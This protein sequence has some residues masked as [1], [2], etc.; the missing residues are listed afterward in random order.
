MLLEHRQNSTWRRQPRSSINREAT[1]IVSEFDQ[2]RDQ[3]F[4]AQRSAGDFVFDDSVAS[5]FDDMISR[6][7]PGYRTIIS[8]IGVMANRH[9]QE[10][11]AIY[12]LGCSL[13]AA[14]F[15]MAE[16]VS[17]KDYRIHAIDNSP[18]M[19]SRLQDRLRSSGTPQIVAQCADIAEVEIINASVVVLN[20]TLQF[21]AKASRD[22]L[23]KKVYEGLRPGGVLIISEKIEFPDPNL[24]DLFTELYYNFKE[25]MGYSKM[26]IAQKRTALENVLVP[27]TLDGHRQRLSAAGFSALDV[28]F[29]C[30][31]FASL[32]A[33]K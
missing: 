30:F 23:I 10:R 11:S 2:S 25:Q 33:V 27:E 15:A 22:A 8:M 16:Q 31:N 5:V 1:K 21:V 19:I 7:I 24:N 12:D 3:L 32:V 6:S 28:W 4:T 9:C 17:C 18:A 26:E 29:Q 14:S 13:G 20:F